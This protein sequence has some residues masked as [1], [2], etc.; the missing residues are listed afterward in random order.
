MCAYQAHHVAEHEARHGQEHDATGRLEQARKV[1]L[2]HDLPPDVAVST[3][4]CCCQSVPASTAQGVTSGHEQVAG[5]L[6]EAET[7]RKSGLRNLRR[8]KP[9]WAQNW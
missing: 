5:M 1:G 7:R 4:R 8:T 6:P 2:L 9:A 3:Q